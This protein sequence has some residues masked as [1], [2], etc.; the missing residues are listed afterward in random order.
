MTHLNLT[1]HTL[2]MQP[3][4]H[5]DRIEHSLEAF[6]W[7]IEEQMERESEPNDWETLAEDSNLEYAAALQEAEGIARHEKALEACDRVRPCSN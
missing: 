7:D 4:I 3:Q 1:K 6:D 5:D 2:C